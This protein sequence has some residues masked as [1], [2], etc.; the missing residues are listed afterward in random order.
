MKYLIVFVLCTLATAKMSLQ[1][2]FGKK[3]VKNT[4]DALCFNALI[5]IFSGIVFLYKVVGCPAPV[6]IYA[7]LGAVAS[8]AFQLTYTRALAAGNV[9]LT[10]LIVNLALVINVLVSYL[11]YGDDISVVRLVGII[12]T[13]LAFILCTDFKGG[14]NSK[15]RKKWLLLAFSAMLSNAASCIVQK[16]FGES[17]YSAHNGAYTSASYVIAAVMAFLVYLFL[18]SRG[19]DKTF[20]IGKRAIFYSMAMGIILAVFVTLNTYALS[21][22]EGTFLFPTYAGGTIVFSAVAGVVLFKD[23]LNFRQVMSVAVGIVAVVL[24]NF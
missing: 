17:A 23:K 3:S 13:V 19:E 11:F 7:A 2:A 14:E 24:M 15:Q 9:S 10:V 21:V 6:W 1:S 12:L 8:V 18:R 4:A 5:F 16:V 20:K 22:V